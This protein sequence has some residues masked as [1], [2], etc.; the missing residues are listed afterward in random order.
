[1]HKK[2]SAILLFPNLAGPEGGIQRINRDILRG[3]GL[4]YPSRGY[5]VLSYHD[6]GRDLA[7]L[8]FPGSIELKPGFGGSGAVKKS[9]YGLNLLRKIRK[10]KPGYL[11]CGHPNFLPACRLAQIVFGVPVII[12]T[13]GIEIW[14]ELNLLQ[15]GAFARAPAT[16]ALSRYS[17]GRLL[18]QVQIP[19]TRTLII[20]PAVAEH[21]TIRAPSAEIRERFG[22]AGKKVIITVA[23]LEKTEHE[24]GYDRVLAALP[25]IVDRVPEIKYLLIGEGDDLDRIRELV[26]LRGLDRYVALAGG[27]PNHRLPEY[28][29]S[30]DC[31]VM[32]SQKEGF[33]I[34]FAEAAACGI[35]VIAGNR[36]GS[37]EALQGGKT[38]L[39]IDPRSVDDI[40][41]AVAAV[42]R[43]DL[44]RKLLDREFL[45]KTA[46]EA[47][48]FPVFL[49]RL[50]GLLAQFEEPGLR[51]RERANSRI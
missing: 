33:G 23:R 17:L 29:N 15:K 24:K 47:F 51:P 40:A 12:W 42:L 48:G 25:E 10:N 36:D 27:V 50:R 20:P 6:T 46:L 38:G 39:L 41:G 26:S 4:L 2:L 43:G 19:P 45:R 3:I 18:S 44:D 14:R 34:V 16:V 30:A 7:G 5:S 32:P 11:I 31:F 13:Y 22:L 28:F 35:P 49:R 8:D 1:M 9:A 21:F 37:V